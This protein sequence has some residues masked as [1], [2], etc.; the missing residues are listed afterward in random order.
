M[1]SADGEGR[2]EGGD[3]RRDWG[4]RKEGLHPGVKGLKDI[5]ELLG[6]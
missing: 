6:K 2:M 5:K 4:G 3:K 1:D